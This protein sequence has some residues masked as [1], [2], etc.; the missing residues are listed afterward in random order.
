MRLQRTY[1]FKSVNMPSFNAA[2]LGLAASA[3]MVLAHGHVREVVVGEKTYPG[4]ERWAEN[5]DM[6]Q[7]VTWSFSTEDEGPVPVGKLAHPDIICHQDAQNAQAHVPIAAGGEMKVR[8]FNTIGGFEHPGPELHYLAS[9]GGSTCDQVDKESLQFVKFYEKGLVTPGLPESQVWATSE[10]HKNVVKVEDGWI[11]EFTVKIP[12]DTPSGNYVLRHEL[13]GLHRAH[14]QD[15]EFYPQVGLLPPF[16]F[17]LFYSYIAP[18]FQRL[19]F[20]TS[21]LKLGLI[22]HCNSTSHV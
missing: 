9:C 2:L 17:P 19:S 10:V 11:D 1:I 3:T 8:R 14:L 18:Y 12:S 4:Y 7:I 6:S 22:P 15:A 20:H 16:L 5:Q 21:P 13:F